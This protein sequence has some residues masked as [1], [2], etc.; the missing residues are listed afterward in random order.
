M[1]VCRDKYCAMSVEEHSRASERPREEG[2]EQKGRCRFTFQIQIF[3]RKMTLFFLAGTNYV[4]T[5]LY[6][7]R[8]RYM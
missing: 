2:K 8:Y 4:G 6:L 7:D 5:Y 1:Y 3:V